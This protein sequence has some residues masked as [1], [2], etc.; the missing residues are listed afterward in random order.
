MCSLDLQYVAEDNHNWRLHDCKFITAKGQQMTGAKLG[1]TTA[2]NGSLCPRIDAFEHSN[3]GHKDFT[4][5]D[6]T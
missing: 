2:S 6:S 4:S 5:S 3:N 1:M